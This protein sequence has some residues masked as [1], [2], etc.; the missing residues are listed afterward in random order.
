MRTILLLLL[1]AFP[2]FI[3]AQTIKDERSVNWV[4]GQGNNNISIIFKGAWSTNS[5]D[6]IEHFKYQILRTSSNVLKN[7]DSTALYG[8][9]TVKALKNIAGGE[10]IRTKLNVAS[11]V[12]FITFQ[13][14]PCKEFTFIFVDTKNRITNSNFSVPAKQTIS[15]LKDSIFTYQNQLIQIQ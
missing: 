11:Y 7:I 5:S 15:I 2:L 6:Y 3:Q 9:V 13:D 8:E 10:C 1:I 12:G 14:L 4:Y